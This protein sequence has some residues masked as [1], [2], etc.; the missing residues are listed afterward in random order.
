M[1]RSAPP[2]VPFAL[3]QFTDSACPT[4]GFAH[5]SGVE[6]LVKV[7]LIRD[8]G[9]LLAVLTCYVEESLPGR[10]LA[11]VGHAWDAGRNGDPT[12]VTTLVRERIATRLTRSARDA[13]GQRGQALLRVVEAV[14]GRD[15]LSTAAA[16]SHAVLFG[17]AGSAVGADRRSVLRASAF[18]QV[19][20]M[21]QA[22]VRLGRIGP[23][24]AQHVLGR[25]AGP[26]ERAVEE[27]EERTHGEWHGFSPTWEL[28][29]S[30]HEHRASGMFI[31]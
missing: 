6:E 21:A 11:F 20:A 23:T 17:V 3:F 25:L 9:D 4:G 14:T 18:N 19:S 26:L 15:P 1:P 30:R 16:G 5:S 31:T 2:S 8:A 12:A 24:G 29:Q 22:A 27:S 7:G 10:E 13:E 28:A